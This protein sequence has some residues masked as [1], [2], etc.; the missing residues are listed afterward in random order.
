M[1]P[2]LRRLVLAIL[3]GHELMRFATVRPDG[4]PQVTTVTYANDGLDLYFACDVASQKLRNI[5]KARKVSLAIDRDCPDW[6][7]IK[8]LSM[9]ATASVLKEPKAIKRALR[10]LGQKFPQMA[11]LSAEDLA[12]TALVKVV[13]KVISVVDYTRGFGHT[14]LVRV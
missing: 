9:A 1:N 5:A 14:D 10:L 4:Y 3:K 7:R 2:K 11:A 13:P 6:N 8:G 12:G